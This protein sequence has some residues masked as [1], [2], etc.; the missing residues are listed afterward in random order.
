MKDVFDA[1]SASQNELLNSMTDATAWAPSS[2]MTALQAQFTEI[3]N[4]SDLMM[5]GLSK[6]LE[7]ISTTHK[8][9]FQKSIADLSEVTQDT[10]A[11]QEAGGMFDAWQDYWTDAAQR[12]VL[13]MDTLRQ[14]GD[15]FLDHEEKGCPPV[16]VY[17][18]EIV[19]DGADLPRPCNYILLKIVPPAGVETKDWKR[20]YI[21]IDP[22]AGHG[23]GIGGFKPDSQVGVA[24]HDGHP[25]YFVGFKRMPEP[26]QT[27]ADVTHAEAHFVRKVMEWHPEAPKPVVTGNCQGGWAT[28]LLAAMNP[29]LTGPIVLNGA[30][31]STWAGRVG[32]NPMR[33]NGG[34]LGGT[35]NAMFYSDLGHGVFDGADIVQNFEMLNPARN[36]F[37]KYYDLYAKVDTEPHRFLEFER[38]WGG[39]FLLNEAEMRWIVE[40]L[41][42]GN[43]LSKNEARLEPGRNIDL[44]QIRSPIIVFASY[45]DNITP[46]QQALN[47]IIDT[48]ADER[49]IAIRGQRIIYM[50]H[51][52]V[53]HLGIFVSSKI[54]KKEHTEVT[55]TLKTIEALAPG[56]YEMKIDDYEGNL[57]DR[58]FTVSF[59]ERKMEDLTKLDDGRDDEVAFA[60]VARASEQQAEFY[61]VAVRPFVQAGVTE[62]SADLRRK[63]HPLRMQRALFSSQ[64]PFV[65]PL[66]EMAD[67]VRTERQPAAKNNPFVVAEHLGAAMVEQSLDLFRDVRDTM[68]ETMFYTMWGTPYAR[69]FGRTHQPGRT[70][71]RKEDLRGLP[72]VQSA[73][74]RIEEGGFCEAVIRML[75]LLAESRGS[76][77]RDRL[78]RSARV[79]TKDEPFKS[80]TADE[81][82]MMLHEQNIIVEFARDEAIAAL[83]KM[84]PSKNDRELAAQV[85]QYIPGAI[86]EMAP[87]TLDLLQ[88]IHTVLELPPVSEDV[89]DDPLAESAPA[90]IESAP[91]TSAQKPVAAATA[92]ATSEKK[93]AP[94]KRTPRKPAGTQNARKP[95]ATP[96]K[97]S[98]EPAE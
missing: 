40:Q 57:L 46:P 63:T 76:V 54:A 64:N 72:A 20:P 50:I 41:F 44:K 65:A 48:Y 11:A 60:A 67:R 28:L 8:A 24:L 39:Y 86:D 68:Y 84:L 98:E 51:D 52:Q 4:M 12:M 95:R 81:R 6:H 77:R 16:L 38:W 21:I 29:D 34:I 9:R 71:K 90:A 30:P 82:A 13:T 1:L 83:P 78:E 7:S 96:S 53:G 19:V 3:S 27:L 5:R 23:A 47:W 62:Q 87:H 33:Y 18:Y 55:S 45:G 74:M 66:A 43:R 32:E 92:A 73:L 37:G 56:L 25:V 22:R 36:Y 88:Q 69:W 80:L 91:K 58:T 35:Y 31:V 94:R 59:H 85:V 10:Q 89:V 2:R 17:D 14:R 15:I 26:G 61:D 75:I 79:L 42:V 49:E 93:T 70:L 97:K